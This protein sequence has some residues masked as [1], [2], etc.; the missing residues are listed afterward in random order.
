MVELEK[1]GVL[2]ELQRHGAAGWEAVGVGKQSHVT[3]V[4]LK[5]PREPHGQ[6][7]MAES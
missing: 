2:E 3:V 1:P 5:R 7:R 6:G 4:L